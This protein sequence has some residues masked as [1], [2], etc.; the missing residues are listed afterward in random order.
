MKGKVVSYISTKKYGFITGD[1]GE[2]YFLHASSLLDKSNESKLVKDV[3]VEFEP[4]PTPKGMSAKKIK[5][6]EVYFKKH[7]VDFFTTKKSHPKYGNVEKSHS[8]NTRFFKDP[9]E[10]REHIKQ[11]A[12]KSG[13]NAILNLSFEKN[14]F[15]SGNYQY[16]V[17]AF[18]GDL[19]LVSGESPCGN[20]QLE[21]DSHEEF[22]SFMSIFDEKFKAIQE[23]E[24]EA[25]RKQLEKN[26]TGYFI[27]IGILFLVFMFAV[28]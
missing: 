8:I 10:G 22:K 24:N 7:L 13:C 18:K 25:R 6:P 3:I 15:S 16:T 2:S 17:H 14:T 11:L 23:I 1:D 5:I 26:H 21:I 12:I 4:T 9:N 28:S 19:A 20:K 27:F